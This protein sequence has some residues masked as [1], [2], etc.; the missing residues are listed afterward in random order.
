[1]PRDSTPCPVRSTYVCRKV[2]SLARP[3]QPTHTATTVA[4][5]AAKDDLLTCLGRVN[6]I[7]RS[8]LHLWTAPGL[9]RSICIQPPCQPTS[10]GWRPPPTQ[11]AAARSR[12]ADHERPVIRGAC[13]PLCLKSSTAARLFACASRTDSDGSFQR[14]STMRRIGV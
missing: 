7:A 11:A 8:R 1:G 5:R 9:A 13:R 4:P 2:E 6:A 3:A 12:L 14:H 10:G